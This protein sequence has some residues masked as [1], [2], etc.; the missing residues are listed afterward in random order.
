MSNPIHI[1]QYPP[2]DLVRKV[3][4]TQL[5]KQPWYVERKDFIAIVAGGIITLAQSVV[6]PIDA[7]TWI[8]VV[9]GIVTWAAALF[10]VS[11]TPGSI[12]KS[13]ETRLAKEAENLE[14]SQPVQA[15]TLFNATAAPAQHDVL[16]M[17][18]EQVAH[19]TETNILG[20]GKECAHGGVAECAPEDEP[21]GAHRLEP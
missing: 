3:V 16:A 11:G 7:P 14:A 10:V 8:H 9:I 15:V 6:I 19:D 20:Y 2:S 1:S 5:N 4:L 13:M 21:G 18:R 12:T 17:E